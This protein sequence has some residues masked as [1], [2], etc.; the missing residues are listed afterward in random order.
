MPHPRSGSKRGV[1]RVRAVK[2][3]SGTKYTV[4][5]VDRRGLSRGL[6]LEWGVKGSKAADIEFTSRR[7]ILQ[8]VANRDVLRTKGSLS[9]AASDIRGTGTSAS[10]DP[11]FAR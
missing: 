9:P 6:L 2:G 4:P 7:A 10:L 3:R 11:L 5:A 8:V 1:P